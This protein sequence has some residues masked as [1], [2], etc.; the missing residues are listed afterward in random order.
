MRAFLRL[1]GAS[2]TYAVGDVFHLQAH[3]PHAEFYGPQG[4][5]YLVGRK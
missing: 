1:C 5:T 2:R 3:T 4:V